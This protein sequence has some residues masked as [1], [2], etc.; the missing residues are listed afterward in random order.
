[1]SLRG[2]DP[3]S[4][5]RKQLPNVLAG[6]GMTRH[7]CSA[8]VANRLLTLCLAQLAAKDRR[9]GLP[10]VEAFGNR[11][12]LTGDLD[13]GWLY[14]QAKDLPLEPALKSE[15]GVLFG[16]GAMLGNPFE[17]VTHVM[18]WDLKPERSTA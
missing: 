17:I 7:E 2:A 4:R 1:M 9:H 10:I 15:R 8:D 13:R 6:R 12:L 14:V 3:A 16:R 11:Y 5:P 18:P